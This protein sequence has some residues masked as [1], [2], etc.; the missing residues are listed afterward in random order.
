MKKN[1]W[2]GILL[3]IS[4]VLMAFQCEEENFSHLTTTKVYNHTDEPIYI[5]G[6]SSLY[7]VGELLPSL[8]VFEGFIENN[9]VLPGDFSQVKTY[10]YEEYPNLPEFSQFLIIRESTIEE[11]G[12]QEIIEKEIFDKR[13]VFSYQELKGKDFC[14][15]YPTTE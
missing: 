3:V 13:Y 2:V 4:F 11:H 15:F 9:K 14:I 12:I 1:L 6:S 8:C 7:K 5:F 10:K